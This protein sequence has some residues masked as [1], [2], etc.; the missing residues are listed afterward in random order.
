MK[1]NLEG[2]RYEVNPENSVLY[3]GETLIN[4]LYID[5]EPDDY[6]FLPLEV[7]SEDCIDSFL[8]ALDNEGVEVV[9][10]EHYDPEQEPFIY[11]INGLC[12]FFAREIDS[13]SVDD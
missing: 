13:L 9:E 1:L 6:L 4:G 12:R 2:E 5:I 10:L 7:L 3:I 11:I 8:D